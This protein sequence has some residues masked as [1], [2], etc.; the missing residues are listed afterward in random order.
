MQHAYKQTLYEQLETLPGGLTG[1][2]LNGQLHTQPRPAGPHAKAESELTYDLVGS[3]GRGRG[4][5][6]GWWI[7]VEPEIHFITDTEVTVPDLAG[8]RKERMPQIPEGHGFEVVPDWI[9]EILSPS[10]ESKDRHIKM[11]IY[12]HYGVAYA[13]LVDPKQRTLEAYGLDSDEWRLLAEV[14]GN[15]CI[16]VAPFEALK[17]ELS[18]LWS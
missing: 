9:C 15:D 18:N 11:P 17:L 4:G 8:W 7:I 10:T 6:G 12:A 14:A 2:I 5:P 13:W 16:A 1:E 3:Y